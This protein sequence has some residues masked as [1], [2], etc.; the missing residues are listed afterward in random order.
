MKFCTE[1]IW[2]RQD[3]K[4]QITWKVRIR[5]NRKYEISSGDSHGVD[6]RIAQKSADVTWIFTVNEEGKGNRP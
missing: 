1:E 4:K 3:L 6:N 5:A 2:S